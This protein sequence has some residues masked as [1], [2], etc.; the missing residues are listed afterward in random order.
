MGRTN[1]PDRLEARR[2]Q[3]IV[4]SQASIDRQGTKGEDGK[5]QQ[6]D[7]GYINHRTA[8]VERLEGRRSVMVPS[9]SVTS[10]GASATV[11]KEI[12][13]K[14]KVDTSYIGYRTGDTANLTRKEERT[15]GDQKYENPAETKYGYEAL[16]GIACR[17]D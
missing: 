12:D 16:K 5:W 2:S 10:T 8:D 11:K 14:W 9:E 3:E 17:P 7:M 6:V 13:G 15:D 1:D 4:A